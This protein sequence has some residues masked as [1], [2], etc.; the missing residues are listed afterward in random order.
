MARVNL[1]KSKAQEL[2]RARERSGKSQYELASELAWV[3]SKI[4][5]IERA[6]I[7]NI[8]EE[9]LTALER[10]LDVKESK[11]AR[12]G[13]RP[14]VIKLFP[15]STKVEGLFTKVVR[16]HHRQKPHFENQVF[17]LVTVR[18]TWHP[19]NLL[20]LEVEL[21]GL[22]GTIHGV[23]HRGDQV[24]IR[25]GERVP[26]MLWGEGIAKRRPGARKR[27]SA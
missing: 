22:Q 13:K 15:G 2:L 10:V 24:P 8:D 1:T 27:S 17:F 9:D 3:R 16:Q 26:I 19:D 18:S 6:E 14:K 21:E 4:K 20:G 11:K 25:A 7:A 5:R 12:V 23:E